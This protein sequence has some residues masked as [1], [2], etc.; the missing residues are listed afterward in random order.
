MKVVATGGLAALIAKETPVIQI[1]NHD[2]TLVG[3]RLIQEAN[4]GL[5]VLEGKRIIVGIT[6]SIAAHKGADW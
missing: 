5:E 6:G 3:L 1:V 2:L 4:R